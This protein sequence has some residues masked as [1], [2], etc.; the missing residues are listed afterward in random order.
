[1]GE[2]FWGGNAIVGW[3]AAIR[4]GGYYLVMPLNGIG[5]Y[6]IQIFTVRLQSF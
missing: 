6:F 3:D 5:P 4:R 1:L 2:I